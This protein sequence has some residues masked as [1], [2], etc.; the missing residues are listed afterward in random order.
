MSDREDR[1]QRA[2]EGVERRIAAEKLPSVLP[3]GQ[4]RS[5]YIREKSRKAVEA[6]DR[7]KK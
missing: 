3:T 6:A 1:M 4:T 2:R 5:D 7:A